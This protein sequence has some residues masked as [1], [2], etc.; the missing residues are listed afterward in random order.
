MSLKNLRYI[1]KNSMGIITCIWYKNGIYLSMLDGNKWGPPFLISDSAVADFSALI[2]SDDNISTCYVDYMDRLIYMPVG[3]EKR[4]CSAS[5]KPYLRKFTIQCKN[6]WSRRK[7]H[8]FYIV[9]HNRRQLLTY[10]RLEGTAYTMPE[11]EGVIV[12]DAKN[13]AVCSD[14]YTVH[15]FL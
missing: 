7:I 4:A 13:Y 1:L 14:G 10:Q 2:D 3:E 15:I 5:R 11:V 8:I 12:R 9:N 6:G